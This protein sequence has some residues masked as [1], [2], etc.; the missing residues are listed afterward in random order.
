M[1]STM[2]VNSDNEPEEMAAYIC[3]AASTMLHVNDPY[4]AMRTYCI[5]I[6]DA[7]NSMLTFRAF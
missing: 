7:Q 5:R 1:A 4:T 3:T 6:L 2:V